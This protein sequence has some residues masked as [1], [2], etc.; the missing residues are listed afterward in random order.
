[1]ILLNDCYLNGIQA[2]IDVAYPHIHPYK[3]LIYSI[4]S[5]INFRKPL[6]DFRKPVFH[7]LLKRLDMIDHGF[8]SNAFGGR[9]LFHNAMLSRR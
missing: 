7:S 3:A 2:L 8:Q 9:L 6:I 5:L 1:M 4:K